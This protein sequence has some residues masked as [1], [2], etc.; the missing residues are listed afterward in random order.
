MPASLHHRL[1]H[2]DWAR[3][4]QALDQD[5]CARL[6][7]VLSP[8][9][10]HSLSRLYPST[11][12]FRS[13]VIM[14]RHGFGRGQ[15]QYF[16]YPLP[17]P[18]AELRQRLY[19]HLVAQAN[20]WNRD[21]QIDISYPADHEAFLQ[22]CHAAGQ[23]RPT[24]LLLQYGPDD[25]NC[26]HQDLY[27]EHVFPLQVVFL[28]SQP[29]TDFTGGELVLTEQRPRMQSRAQV[30]GLKQGDGL[31]FA[32]HHRPVKGARGHYR[33]ALRHGVSRVHSGQRHSLGVI[34]HDAL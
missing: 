1:Q 10:C 29:G 34:F 6:E 14:A 23:Q 27:G 5:G 26:L 13:K 18:V 11:E 2:L 31:I 22:R 28:L 33:V 24:P 16:R 21:M 30:I 25:Y 7:G 8:E 20:R 9:Q 15:Y 3:I 4:E 32:V 12:L 17:E 19:P